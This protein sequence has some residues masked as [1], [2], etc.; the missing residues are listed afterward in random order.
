MV[1]QLRGHGRDVAVVDL[2]VLDILL[3]AGFLYRP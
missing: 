1:L 2:D 3:K